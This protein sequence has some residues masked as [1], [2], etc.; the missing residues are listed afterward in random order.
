M[1]VNKKKKIINSKTRNDGGAADTTVCRIEA[2][3]W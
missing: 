1:E 2:T 3:K